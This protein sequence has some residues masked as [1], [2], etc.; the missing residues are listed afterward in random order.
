[1]SGPFLRREDS[2]KDPCASLCSVDYG[3]DGCLRWLSS[4]YTQSTVCLKSRVPLPSWNAGDI[5]GRSGDVL[6]CLP[7]LPSGRSGRDVQL[8]D[9][10]AGARGAHRA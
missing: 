9:A 2:E 3:S 10:D 5:K 6:S 1:M 8:G 7:P 4:L